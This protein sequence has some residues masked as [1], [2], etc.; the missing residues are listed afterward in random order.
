MVKILSEKFIVIIFSVFVFVIGSPDKSQAKINSNEFISAKAA[1]LID[2]DT[3]TILYQKNPDLRLPPAST[4]KVM[5]A[6]VALEN[7]RLDS[8]VCATKDASRVQPCKVEIRSGEQWRMDDLL[9]CTLLNSANDACVVIAEGTAGSIA[10]FTRQM[11]LKAKEIGANNTRFSNPHGLD[12][13]DHYSTARDL[14]LIFKYAMNNPVF[15]EIVQTESMSIQCPNKRL[16]YLRNHNKLLGRYAGMIGGKTGYTR[17]A[18]KCF[19]GEAQQ[20]GRNLLVCVLGSNNHFKDAVKLLDFGFNGGG[21]NKGN[22]VIKIA[23]HPEISRQVSSPAISSPPS[24]RGS[25]VLQVGSFSDSE[26]A[27]GLNQT[28]SDN[29]Y[30]SFIEK[31]SSKHGVVRHRVKV[32]FYQDLSSAQKTKKC[33]WKYFGINPIILHQGVR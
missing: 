10:N 1:F 2:A 13:R 27:L 25:Y 16:I 22:S 5:T 30:P 26:K 20:N 3:G 6:I 29:G 7:D 12:Q 4:T 31:T 9:R 14:V 11:N 15:R 23:K 32:G 24:K 28:L 17:R 8:V 19:V 33:I 18:S 21:T